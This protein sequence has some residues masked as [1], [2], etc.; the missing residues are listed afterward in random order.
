MWAV[1]RHTLQVV[2]L[3]PAVTEQA[4]ETG[5]HHAGAQELPQHHH[6]GGLQ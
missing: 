2:S 1:A 3:T 4:F 5:E 6:L